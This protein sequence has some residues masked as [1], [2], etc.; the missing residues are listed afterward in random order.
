MKTRQRIPRFDRRWDEII[1]L[2]P[3][4]S[5]RVLLTSAIKRYQLDGTEPQLFKQS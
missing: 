4:E 2:Y 1:A 5:A 3:D